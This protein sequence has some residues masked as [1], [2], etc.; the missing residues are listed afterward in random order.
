MT[1]ERTFEFTDRALKGL[2]IPPKDKPEQVW[3][4]EAE[5]WKQPPHGQVDYFDSKV[6]G[7]GLRISYGGI[8][9]PF[10]A[11]SNSPLPFSSW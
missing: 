9:K 11:R 6:R 8:G 3:D 4:E 1:Q 10:K 2:P 7:L 5:E